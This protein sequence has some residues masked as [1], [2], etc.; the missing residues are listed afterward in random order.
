MQ[1]E[2]VTTPIEQKNGY[3]EPLEGP[4][5]GIEIVEEVIEK[6]NMRLGA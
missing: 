4:G 1:Y 3:V 6:Y 2:L 5:L